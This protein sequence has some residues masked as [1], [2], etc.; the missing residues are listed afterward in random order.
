MDPDGALSQSIG[1]VPPPRTRGPRFGVGREGARSLLVAIVSTVVF[2]GVIGW[3]VVN[4]PGWPRF[5][6]SFLN[7]PLF[8][9]SLPKLLAKFLVNIQLFLLAEVLILVF[10]LLLA[11]LRGLPGPVFFPVRLLATAYVDI[12]RALPGLLIVIVLGIGVP[13]LRIEGVPKDEFFYAVIA[14]TLV[15]SAYV[16]E[17]YRAGIESIHP[18]QQAAARSL[19]LSQ[20]QAMR[21]V[22]VPQAVR[23]VIPPLLNDFIGL[24][25]DTVLVST[26]GVV[27]IF[28][29]S[30]I[31]VAAN[32]NFTPYV[33]TALVFLVITIPLARFTDWLVA[34]QRRQGKGQ[35]A[36]GRRNGIFF[37]SR[38]SAAPG[39][40]P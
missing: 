26:I 16:S 2:F 15:Y 20:L 8:W 5:Q 13:A 3:V 18:S 35:V 39:E 28:R 29:Q 9:E 31:L 21:F 38:R 33:A 36:S 12:F 6:E 11:V 19:G 34:R 10:G 40:T 7:G 4:S 32:F 14:L 22:V 24:Q 23:R 30:Q 17:V 27:E 25:K 37:G 1:S